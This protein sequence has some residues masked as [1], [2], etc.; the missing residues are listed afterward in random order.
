MKIDTFRV[1]VCVCVCAM[2]LYPIEPDYIFQYL[3]KALILTWFCVFR[4]VSPI[5]KPE[6]RS[7]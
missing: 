5:Q 7:I 3:H 4:L 6:I 1:A 2:D